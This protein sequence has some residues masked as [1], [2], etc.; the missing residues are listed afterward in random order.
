MWTSMVMEVFTTVLL[1]LLLPLSRATQ[2]SD[3]PETFHG[4]QD[5]QSVVYSTLGLISNGIKEFYATLTDEERVIVD[6]VDANNTEP[7]YAAGYRIYNK[8]L[9][10]RADDFLNNEAL[11]ILQLDAPA[12]NFYLNASLLIRSSDGRQLLQWSI[13]RIKMGIPKQNK[14]YDYGPQEEHLP[15]NPSAFKLPPEHVRRMVLIDGSNMIHSAGCAGKNLRD[16]KVNSYKLNGTPL[17]VIVHK[18]LQAGFEVYVALKEYFKKAHEDRKENID[19][20]NVI[21]E[22]EK[23]GILY[24]IEDR[25]DDDYVLLHSAQ[26]YNG[27]IISN[28]SF[29]QTKYHRFADIKSRAV[30][31]FYC[32]SEVNATEMYKP[33]NIVDMFIRLTLRNFLKIKFHLNHIRISI[34]FFQMQLQARKIPTIR[35]FANNTSSLNNPISTTTL[36]NG[37]LFLD[38]S[39]HQC[40]NLAEYMQFEYCDTH[41]QVCKRVPSLHYFKTTDKRC[42]KTYNEFKKYLEHHNLRHNIL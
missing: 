41:M 7:T 2:I 18:L 26:H 3:V 5:R 42:P 20:A 29:S 10:D 6:L 15:L 27:V 12:R 37:Q 39:D 22:L 19:N 31:F 9:G 21:T 14:K 36:S 4:K 40:N 23:L 11:R 1:L 28:D 33:E 13:G 25:K 24:Y 32:Q 8:E 30:N 38:D 35:C 17:L 34:L 16:V